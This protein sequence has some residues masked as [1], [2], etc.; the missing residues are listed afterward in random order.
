MIRGF[1]PERRSLSAEQGAKPLGHFAN[2][3]SLGVRFPPQL[4][5]KLNAAL[6]GL[7][8]TV[9]PEKHLDAAGGVT[10]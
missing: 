8:G 10:K 5:A 2:L 4:E 1:R 7:A 3:D 9:C 6:R